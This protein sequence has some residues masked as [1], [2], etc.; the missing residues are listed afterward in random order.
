MGGPL[1]WYGAI[2]TIIAAGLIASDLSRKITGWA[3]VLFVTVSVAWIAAGLLNDN[4]PIAIQNAAMLI[5]NG[6]GV[7]Q[8]LLNRK[9]KRELELMQECAKQ[10]QEKVEAETA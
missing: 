5:V 7:Y 8:Y 1:E 9:K 4:R 10:A 2:G 3:F 6:W